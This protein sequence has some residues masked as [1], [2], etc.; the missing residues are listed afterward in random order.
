MRCKK[1]KI[2]IERR[3]KGKMKE[4]GNKRKEEVKKIERKGR[5]RKRN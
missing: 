3:G 2:K 5:D 1:L 4:V